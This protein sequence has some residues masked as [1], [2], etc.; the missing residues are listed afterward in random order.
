MSIINERDSLSLSLQDVDEVIK[1]PEFQEKDFMDVYWYGATI[2]EKILSLILSK[3]DKPYLLSEIPGLLNEYTGIKATKIEIK[4]AMD[5][6]VK[7][8]S[9]LKK[10][11]G[12]YV[13]NVKSFPQVISE[14]IVFDEYL[15]ILTEEYQMKEEL[16]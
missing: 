9:I 2:L 8:R 12:G 7:L 15:G 6:L 3:K 13:F 5:R 1:N 4:A 11:K 14:S 10:S 16:K